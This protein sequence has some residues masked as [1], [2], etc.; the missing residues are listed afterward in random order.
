MRVIERMRAIEGARGRAHAKE[1]A[2]AIERGGRHRETVRDGL[3]VGG[4]GEGTSRGRGR[5][6]GAVLTRLVDAS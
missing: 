3:E 1:R 4:A 6:V 2:R 5:V